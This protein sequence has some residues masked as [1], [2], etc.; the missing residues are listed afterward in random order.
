MTKNKTIMQLISKILF[1]CLVINTLPVSF[2]AHAK[3]LKPHDLVAL[4]QE[5]NIDRD[6]RRVKKTVTTLKILK[7]TVPLVVLG[8]GTVIAAVVA[9]LVAIF[10]LV[11]RK[12]L[13]K[14][15]GDQIGKLNKLISRKKIEAEDLGNLVGKNVKGRLLG[16][17]EDASKIIK[18][19]VGKV[20]GSAEQKNVVE[21]LISNMKNLGKVKDLFSEKLI[22]NFDKASAFIKQSL[23]EQG[24]VEVSSKTAK[25][26]LEQLK[27]LEEF[28]KKTHINELVKNHVLVLT[29]SITGIKKKVEFTKKAQKKMPA[30][31]K[32]LTP[33]ISVFTGLFGF[34]GTAF[35]SLLVRFKFSKKA[36]STSVDLAR[37]LEKFEEEFPGIL[38]PK[39]RHLLAKFKKLAGDMTIRGILENI[40]LRAKLVT[41]TNEVIQEK[42]ELTKD[43]GGEKEAQNLLRKYFTLRLRKALI[44]RGRGKFI[45]SWWTKKKIEKMEK[46]YSLLKDATKDAV[47]KYIQEANKIFERFNELLVEAVVEG[48]VTPKKAVRLEPII[49]L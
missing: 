32:K 44:Q 12:K 47:G 9:V 23:T 4:R 24:S 25:S 22:S 18:A 3:T 2:P 38:T 43:L 35:L 26:M 36:F 6:V 14:G 17:I 10:I 1:V 5:L 20:I 45:F 31:L 33:I 30:I 15:L 42:S 8:A 29:N 46:E 39:E 13:K 41:L 7:H 34:L 48:K 49:P 28:F 11:F 21:F 27:N 40:D 37:K 16:D 19:N